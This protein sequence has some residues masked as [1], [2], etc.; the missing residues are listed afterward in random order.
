MNNEKEKDHKN[1]LIELYNNVEVA[2]KTQKKED[3]NN[4]LDFTNFKNYDSEVLQYIRYLKCKLKLINIIVIINQI[5]DKDDIKSFIE[6]NYTNTIRNTNIKVNSVKF[7]SLKRM[8]FYLHS[9]IK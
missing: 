1:D 6:D 3:I 2:L 4:I 7:R 8:Y 9:S 5:F